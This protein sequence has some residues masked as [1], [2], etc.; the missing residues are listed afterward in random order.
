MAAGRR[1]A[2]SSSWR[3]NGVAPPVTVQRFFSMQSMPSSA[4]QTSISTLVAPH[5]HGMSKAQNAPVMC[6]T[7]EGMKT[8]SD[9]PID[10]ASRIERTR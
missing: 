6:V 10:H 1:A 5:A 7:G 2:V 8:T 4:L 3:R 9:G